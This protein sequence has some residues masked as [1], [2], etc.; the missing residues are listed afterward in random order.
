MYAQ[1]STNILAVTLCGNRRT[2]HHLPPNL[3]CGECPPGTT[4][5][6]LW[7]AKQLYDSAFNPESGKK[8]IIIGRM[9]FQVPGNMFISGMMLTF[10][11]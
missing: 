6:Q 7:R 11:K 3:R 1:E 5:E 10:F 4:E 2:T 8:K 9:S